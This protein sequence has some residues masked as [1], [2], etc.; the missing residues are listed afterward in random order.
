M[1]TIGTIQVQ[2]TA[3]GYGGAAA[4]VQVTAPKFLVYTS[5]SRYTTSPRS[6]ITVY[7]ADA[8][9]N[10][11][12]TTEDVVVT[13]VSSAPS[14]AVIDSLTVTIPAGSY[15]DQGATWSP[16]QI[17]TSR[18]TASDARSVYY[19]YG[20]GFADVTVSTPYLSL[21]WNSRNLGIGQY[22]DYAYP[23]TPDNQAAPLVVNLTHAGTPRTATF[24]NL[25]TTPITSVTIPQGTSYQYFRIAGTAVGTDSLIASAVTPAHVPDTAYTV[26][27]LGRVD[28]IGSWPA[29]LAVGDSVLVTLY[30]RDQ[31]T[32]THNV[33]NDEIFTLAPNANIEFRLGGSAVT[34]VTIPAG[35]YYV[36]FYVVGLSAGTG[37]VQIT[38]ADYQTYAPTVTVQ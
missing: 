2:A 18:I 7:A 6:T 8:N 14:V 35:Q 31:T 29:N 34:Q 1:D 33:L 20:D 11:H 13:L 37:S 23:S 27:T 19:E 26:V 15:Y 3:T 30:A 9:G 32:N 17:G 28:P 25:T 24:G 21:S 10:T 38:N 16:G 4:S 22:D 12:L 36:Q 5:T